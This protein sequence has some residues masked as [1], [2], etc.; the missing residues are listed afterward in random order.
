M[1]VQIEFLWDEKNYTEHK[2]NCENKN[3]SE[4]SDTTNDT[5][6]SSTQ[7]DWRDITDPKLRKKTYMKIYRETNKQKLKEQKKY[8]YE[9]NK[10][11]IN[12]QKKVYRKK[13]KDKIKQYL[14]KNKDKFKQQRKE[15]NIKNADKKRQYQKN[16]IKNDIQYKL[17]RNLRK[18]LHSAIKNNQKLGSA[19]KDLGCTIDEL[20]IYL[21]SKFQEGMTWENWNLY[22][23]H[24]DHI[25]PL[26]LFDLTDKNQFLQAVHYTNLQPL[27]A[28]DN[29]SKNDKY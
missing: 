23:W 21:E 22:G 25:K 24:I 6:I 17:S 11:T 20:K 27:W 28:E 18:R 3:V 14:E 13:N 15:Y 29:L 16:K 8:W 12:E 1:E 7:I 19:V 4:T 9:L 2:T 26:S 10:Q 5:K